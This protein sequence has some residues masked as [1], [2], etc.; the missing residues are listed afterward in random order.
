[1]L[2]FIYLKKDEIGITKQ[3]M[4]KVHQLVYTISMLYRYLILIIRSLLTIYN[5]D[6]CDLLHKYE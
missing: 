4:N 2:E 6:S 5:W 1:M 3:E